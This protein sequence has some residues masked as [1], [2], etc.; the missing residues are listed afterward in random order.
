MTID[1][2]AILLIPEL[3]KIT[4]IN[5]RLIET[6]SLDNKSNFRLMA[7]KMSIGLTKYPPNNVA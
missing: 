7:I 1:E 3:E 5:N 4:K 6:K 2:N